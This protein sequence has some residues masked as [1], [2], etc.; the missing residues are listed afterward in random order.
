MKNRKQLTIIFFAIVFIH[1]IL[2]SLL[3]DRSKLVPTKLIPNII[4]LLFLIK[5]R[6]N[7][8][9]EGRLFGYVIALVFILI[10]DVCLLFPKYFSYGLITYIFAQFVYS[11]IFLNRENIS[12]TNLVWFLLYGLCAGLLFLPKVAPNLFIPVSIY[13]FA[14]MIMGYSVFS[15]LGSRFSLLKIGAFL[16]IFSDTLL[17]FIRLNHITFPIWNPIILITYFSAQFGLILGSVK[18]EKS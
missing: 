7:L 15:N 13:I 16:F 9:F 17:G 4:L 14:L 10:G 6:D 3:E 5:N 2:D 8:I 12:I 11:F 1:I 18:N